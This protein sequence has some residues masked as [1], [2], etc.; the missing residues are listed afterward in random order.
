MSFGYVFWVFCLTHGIFQTQIPLPRP[1]YRRQAGRCGGRVGETDPGGDL[2]SLFVEV[3]WILLARRVS[4]SC[5]LQAKQGLEHAEA[6]WAGVVFQE[7]AGFDRQDPGFAQAKFIL[8]GITKFQ[9]PNFFFRVCFASLR[10]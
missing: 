9:R 10:D 3:Q 5:H 7:E 6:G 2:F 1:S 8:E 4:P